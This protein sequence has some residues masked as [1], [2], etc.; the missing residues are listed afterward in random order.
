[1]DH[2]GLVRDSVFSVRPQ[3][4]EKSKMAETNISKKNCEF[5]SNF[6][7]VHMEKLLLLQVTLKVILFF[8]LG[9]FVLEKYIASTRFKSFQ[10]KFESLE[11]FDLVLELTIHRKRL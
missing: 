5:S 11:L 3:A 1:M 2:L 9:N 10:K 6:F 4:A 7:A 8:V